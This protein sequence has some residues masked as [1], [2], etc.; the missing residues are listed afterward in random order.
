MATQVRPT[1]DELA[2]QYGTDKS[3]AQHN[4]TA[5]YEP[6]LASR[7]DKSISLLEL[8]WGGHE[9]PAAGGNSARMWA[10]YFSSP[11]VSVI[12]LEPKRPG[13]LPAGLHLYHGSQADPDTI[14]RAAD[15]AGPFD[16]IIDDASH[17]F[18]LTISSF[19]LLW[20]HL[21]SGGLYI[22][23]DTHAAYHDFYYGRT[24]A[25]QNPNRPAS[26]G[27]QTSMQFFKRL[28]DEVNFRGRGD[29]DL[30]PA[31][32]SLG[33]DI[34]LADVPLQHGGHGQMMSHCP[35]SLAT[36]TDSGRSP[37]L[38]KLV[39]SCLAAVA[40]ARPPTTARLRP[41]VS[42]AGRRP[43]RRRCPVC[44][45]RSRQRGSAHHDS[46][47]SRIPSRRWHAMCLG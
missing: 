7:R 8:G 16:V 19:A 34:A 4:Y 2:L 28:A 46:R 38:A 29:W 14:A 42:R 3:S 30:F 27:R 13:P 6:L 15:D 43:A 39:L 40:G 44:A 17:Q 26:G 1:L 25:N 12:E 41:L 18:S 35:A 5:I 9:D 32:Y 36:P 23:E 22:V 37:S 10:D 31:Q 33:Y 11:I 24:E 47:H 21:A 45:G 20:P